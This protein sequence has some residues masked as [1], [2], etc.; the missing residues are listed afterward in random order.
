MLAPLLIG[1][2]RG[3]V[4]LY[5]LVA[6]INAWGDNAR[7]GWPLGKTGANFSLDGVRALASVLAEDRTGNAQ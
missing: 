4:L 3:C 5:S 1:V 7:F 2:N 6:K